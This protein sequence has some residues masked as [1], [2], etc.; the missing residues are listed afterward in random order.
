MTSTPGASVPRASFASRGGE[1][2][3]PAAGGWLLPVVVLL[4]GWALSGW[5][6]VLLQRAAAQREEQFFD[7]RVAEAEAAIRVRMDHYTDALHGGTS[8]FA[9]TKMADRNQWRIFTDSLQLRTR[10]P[11]INGLGVVLAVPPDGVEK[12]R[13]SVREPGEPEPE[14]K[15]FPAT[16]DGPP[17]EM[18]YLI[19]YVEGNPV[20]RPPIGRNIA[21]EPSRRRAAEL[22]RD[23][24]RP[25]INRRIPGS[26]D[27]QRRSGLLLYVPLYAQNVALDTLEQ[28]RAALLGWVYAQVYPEVFLDGV[29]G[30]MGKALRLHFFEAGGRDR[31]TLLYASEG[32]VEDPVPD[33]ERVTEL[34]IAG[35]PFQLG[36]RRGPGF[37]A[38][39]RSPAVWVAGSMA[40]STLF[41]AGLVTSLQSVGRRANAI[42]AVRTR[43]LA[44]SEERFRQA[45]DAAG[46]GMAMMALDGRWLRVNQSLCEIVGYSEAKL[47]H[48]RF[49]DITH[50]DDL[51]ADLALMR[52]LIEG[53]RRFYQL[54]KRFFHHDGHTVWIRLTA[55]LVR[56]EHDTPLHCIA[57]VEDITARK[58]L[59]G[60]LANA[61]DEAVEAALLK[62]EFLATMIDEIRP[63]IN[64]VM[65]ASQ[66]LREGPLT[67]VQSAQVRT[68]EAA[69]DSLL[70]MSGDILDFSKIEAG[71]I[72]LEA[73]CFNLRECVNQVLALFAERAR[74]KG[75]RLEATVADRV[76]V[77][78]L[79]DAKRLQQILVN[80]LGNA[81][82]L[83]DVGEVRV[84]LTAEALD[85][86][87]GRQRLKFAVRDTGAGMPAEKI[88][89][90]FKSFS[91]VD[92]STRRLGGTGLGLAISSRLAE[93]MGG[94]MWAQSEPGRGSTFHFTVLVQPRDPA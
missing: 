69:G 24:G 6:F 50:P 33:F 37:P 46:I 26:R 8:F 87:S 56:D 16:T 92:A 47:L 39:E 41:L 62:S 45:F 59:E 77:E 48:K 30:P 78:A 60:N 35:Q 28:R 19:T 40:I 91:P 34:L 76:P 89:Q 81:I 83:T 55:S 49:Q 51:T 71:Q 68:V 57:H 93:L 29:L 14:I 61:R 31:S 25:Q 53:R 67:P 82:K 44:A 74:R 10:Y 42:A 66:I 12:W 20:D 86:T 79:A 1:A 4:A 22:A 11:G 70:T 94:T 21:T 38:V 5:M 75:I 36:W 23:T 54:E 2:S 18:K 58:R 85:A 32:A 80:L 65:A 88:E 9:A 52:E 90:V 84:S 64:E 7:E 43:E 73:V 72:D 17:G 13:A 63:P 3:P 27:T 15:P